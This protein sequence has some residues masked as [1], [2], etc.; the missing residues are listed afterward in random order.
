MRLRRI[1]PFAGIG[2]LV[3]AVCL[4]WSHR[5]IDPIGGI[6]YDGWDGGTSERLCSNQL[7]LRSRRRYERIVKYDL[8]ILLW[9]ISKGKSGVQ[10]RCCRSELFIL[11]SSPV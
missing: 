2:V 10:L 7:R 6:G 4:R 11:D 5:R 9:M 3:V 1:S 8:E